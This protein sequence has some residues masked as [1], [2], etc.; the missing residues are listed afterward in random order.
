MGYLLFCS[1]FSSMYFALRYY[2][3]RGIEKKPM[4]GLKKNGKKNPCMFLFTG[5]AVGK[6]A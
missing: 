3:V 2:K 4:L 6:N 5:T 1:L